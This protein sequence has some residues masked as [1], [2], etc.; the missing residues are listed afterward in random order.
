LHKSPSPGVA[1]RYAARAGMVFPTHAHRDWEF[2]Y[3]T[4]GSVRVS[5]GDESLIATAGMLVMTP[6]GTPHSET[7]QTDYSNHYL[8]VVADPRFP[9]PTMVR[10]DAAG[11]MSRVLESLTEEDPT[12]E[13]MRGLLF[14]Q[15]NILI[16]R[17]GPAGT[18]A[19]PRRQ[20]VLRA[21]RRFRDRVSEPFTLAALAGELGVST[22]TLRSAFAEE[23]GMSPRD[24][25]M[26]LRMQHV[27]AR[28]RTS[29]LT[30]DN[31]AMLTGFSSASHLSRAVRQATGRSPREIRRV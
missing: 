23:R 13:V 14:Q 6:P 17:A 8:Q 22:S 5:Q 4:R 12:E 2:V 21:E 15:L 20:L 30:L 26:E 3:Y 18:P 10:D 24:R 1:G 7:A 9:W 25:F 28:L 16:E 11:N 27:L 19:S 31:L 29:T